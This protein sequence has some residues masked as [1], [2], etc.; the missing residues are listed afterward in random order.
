M[1]IKKVLWAKQRR[2]GEVVAAWE[3]R[4]ERLEIGAVGA[5]VAAGNRGLQAETRF[6]PQVLQSVTVVGG[7]GPRADVARAET[8]ELIHGFVIE[9]PMAQPPKESSA[10]RMPLFAA[11]ALRIDGARV[12]Q[13]EI[14]EVQFDARQ[15]RKRHG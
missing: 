8:P 14:V 5:T 3:Q 15:T 11:S 9:I 1:H 4:I 6:A 2:F 7:D 13:A 12:V 10:N